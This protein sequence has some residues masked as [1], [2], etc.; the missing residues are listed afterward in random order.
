MAVRRQ[1]AID[2]EDG[3]RLSVSDVGSS[4]AVGT[5]VLLHSWAMA[6]RAWDDVIAKI[7]FISPNI[8]VIAY[9]AR[10]HGSSSAA[11]SCDIGGL[12]DDL[13][14]VLSRLVPSGPIVLVG[15]AMGGSTM[16]NLAGRY[17]ELIEERVDGAVFIATPASPLRSVGRRSK[18][19]DVLAK[20]NSLALRRGT[21]GRMP[22]SVLR[23][24]IRAVGGDG[25]SR[26]ALDA[27]TSQ[28]VESDP[29]TMLALLESLVSAD[30]TGAAEAYSGIPVVVMSAGADRLVPPSY[31]RQISEELDGA[32]H[33]SV[34]GSGHFLPIEKPDE[35]ASVIVGAVVDAL[36][37]NRLS[38]SA[39][40]G[41]RE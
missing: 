14:A 24:A 35:V 8:R 12:T 15:H 30:L 2:L 37:A 7:E 26:R 16:L 10:G 34:P 25:L 38:S 17:R 31:S 22:I 23:Q 33:V 39:V 9:D 21:I 32:R 6:S 29:R 5:V 40:S 28:V 41:C 13:V 18:T 3:C 36:G 1:Y 19:Y 27:A 20:I 4:K 11:E